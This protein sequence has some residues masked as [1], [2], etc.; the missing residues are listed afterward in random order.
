[1]LCYYPSARSKVIT[2]GK[3]SKIIDVVD[4]QDHKVLSYDGSVITVFN[5][6]NRGYDPIAGYILAIPETSEKQRDC[7]VGNSRVT[8]YIFTS[9]GLWEKTDKRRWALITPESCEVKIGDVTMSF[10][11]GDACGGLHQKPSR[12]LVYPHSDSTFQ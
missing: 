3:S 1:M 4:D 5:K 8:G 7:Y 10:P 2:H 6:P 11:L 12:I 9:Y